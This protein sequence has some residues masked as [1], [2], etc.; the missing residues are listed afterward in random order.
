MHA[1]IEYTLDVVQAHMHYIWYLTDE[2]VL[3]W[4]EVKVLSPVR[5]VAFGPGRVVAP[6]E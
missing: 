1:L 5:S 2:V 6:E 4:M 3:P